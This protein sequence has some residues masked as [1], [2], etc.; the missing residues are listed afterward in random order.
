MKVRRALIV[1]KKSNY[2]IRALERKEEHFL[3]LIE[4]DHPTVAHSRRVYEEHQA[5]LSKTKR[6]L[7]ELEI[8]YDSVPRYNLGK[9]LA[10]D[11]V[12]TVGG[13]G[14]FLDSARR[15]KRG[16]LLGVNSNPNDSVGNFCAVTVDE[17]EKKLRQL[18]AGTVRPK[19]IPRIEVLLEGRRLGSPVLN[20][21]LFAN[22]H[23]SGMS[24]YYIAV[25]AGHSQRSLQYHEHRSS[26]VWV[27]APAGTTAAIR[28]AGGPHLSLTARR[29]AYQV[30]EPD[31]SRGQHYQL[32]RGIVSANKTL[33]LV[34]KMEG[35][36]VFFDGTHKEY[37]VERGQ[38]L[39]IRLAKD[40][41]QVIL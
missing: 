15:T 41:L 20:E 26:G 1:Y 24:R 28:S 11:L 31:R 3:R 36:K 21:I 5:A 38:T 29:F 9:S 12:V 14:T 27:A 2:E 18:L 10:A 40:P 34:A 37:V 8:S 35:M 30:R 4:K 22:A 17:L 19:K 39:T 16:V 32:L 13:D 25:G 33:Y 23:P 6:I 7:G